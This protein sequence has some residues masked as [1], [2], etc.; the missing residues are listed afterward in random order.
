MEQSK[1]LDK[2]RKLLNVA[3]DPATASE[4]AESYRERAEAL[5]RDY[6]LEQEDLLAENP[7]SVE[8]VQVEINLVDALVRNALRYVDLFSSIAW[9]CGV[10]F[11]YRSE[12]RDG[13]RAYVAYV[14]GYEVD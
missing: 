5:M 6:R 11:A 9:H 10:W 2:V 3:D 13:K 8:P 4:M 12:S 14:V 7:T 1:V